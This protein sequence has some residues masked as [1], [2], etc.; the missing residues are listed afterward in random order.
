LRRPNNEDVCTVDLERGYYLV[1]DGMGGEGAGEIASSLF[2]ESAATVFQGAP[3][4]NEAQVIKRVQETY[5][6]AT[7][8]I[9]KYVMQNPDH[10][11]MGC[12]AELMAFSDQSFVLGHIGDSRSYRF[13]NRQ[14]QQLTVDHSLVQEQMESGLLSP[15]K[16]RL[17]PLKN[18]ITRAVGIADDISPDLICEPLC[19]DDVF[20]LCSDGLTDLVD[21][22]HI[23]AALR[24]D[25]PLD[26]KVDALI[27]AAL[28]AGGKDNVTVVLL[29]TRC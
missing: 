8:R 5:R 16:A 13:R 15:E 25:A 10:Q 17:H 18:I 2:A 19:H 27:D 24:T 22:D 29:A 28:K 6:L 4:P 26:R 1:A 3:T 12:T 11:G 20:L 23:A 7:H 9:L 21:D 14:L